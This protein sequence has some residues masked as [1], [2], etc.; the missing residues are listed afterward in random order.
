[1]SRVKGVSVRKSIIA[2]LVF[3]FASGL[4]G[5]FK[6][7]FEKVEIK[8]G[9]YLFE[10]NEEVKV[11]FT[12][13]AGLLKE[14][15]GIKINCRI[16]F[17]DAVLAEY[18]SNLSE[19]LSWNTKD[20]QK[21]EYKIELSAGKESRKEEYFY[22]YPAHENKLKEL[23]GRAVN[24]EL[25]KDRLAQPIIPNVYVRLENLENLWVEAAK[26]Q[27]AANFFMARACEAEEIVAELERDGDYFF[28]KR[29]SFVRAYKSKDDGSYQPYSVDLPEDYGGAEKYPLLV[30]LHGS[31]KDPTK[32]DWM[33]W[34]LYYGHNEA[35]PKEGVFRKII[36]VSPYGRGNSGYEGLGEKDV[37]EVINDMIKNYSIDPDRI[38]IKGHS[39]GAFGGVLLAMRNPGYFA[40]GAF[41][42]GGCRQLNWLENG[43]Y[44]PS[45]FI[46]GKD[47]ATV[48][49]LESVKMSEKMQALGFNSSLTILPKVGH[50]GF[51]KDLS[52][53]I[54]EYFLK[55]KR[56]A[57]PKSVVFTTNTLNYNSSYWFEVSGL[58][59]SNEFAKVKALVE[60]NTVNFELANVESFKIT[61]SEMLL[62]LK[63][64][65]TININGK[66]LLVDKV[67]DDKVIIFKEENDSW[68][69]ASSRKASNL[70]SLSKRKG[71]CGP[72]DDVFSS[73]FIIVYGTKGPEAAVKANKEAAEELLKQ[74]NGRCQGDYIILP[75]SEVMKEQIAEYNLVL[76]GDP[77]SNTLT[78][79]I[80]DMLPLKVKNGAFIFGGRELKGESMSAR[81]IYPNPLNPEKYVAV[82][83]G[84][85]PKPEGKQ[86]APRLPDYLIISG[87]E[88]INGYFSNNWDSPRDK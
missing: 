34:A 61:L 69:Q 66:K 13:P 49:Y 23:Y 8:P 40:A 33:K 74:Q 37:F 36:Q 79:K 25:L 84:S 51:P 59:K 50:M 54:V 75:D 10:K 30:Y 88:N 58:K 32:E 72:Y 2:L 68:T 77:D 86:R 78:A 38:Y 44:L 48:N 26:T 43:M 12:F 73:S 45:Y 87:T 3:S 46:H 81:F 18:S 17:K 55:Y 70:L 16:I 27:K 64:V 63:K 21:G 62:D 47:D 57:W 24:M 1:M 65:I 22:I 5:D 56:D 71:L 9:K 83:Y 39:M 82:N 53:H 67:P 4:Y 76:V 11:N 29:G 20:S 6:D 60:G 31:M 85:L 42:S 52:A 19:G 35:K 28:K 7:L 80:N 15:D 41:M 14:A